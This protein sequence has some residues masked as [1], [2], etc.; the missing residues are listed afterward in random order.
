MNRRRSAT[1]GLLC[2]MVQGVV[3]AG[4]T[5]LTF[6]GN[7]KLVKTPGGQPA[8]QLTPSQGSTQGSVFTTNQ[9]QFD[10]ELRFH[11]FFQFQINPGPACPGDGMAFVVQTQ[12]PNA[13]GGGGGGLGYKGIHPSVAV[14]FDAF[15]NSPFDPNN[16]HVAILTQ[17]LLNDLDP[18]APYGVVNCTS[19]IGVFGCI[20]NGDIWSVWID[21]DGKNLSVAVADD[22]GTRPP[23]L[24]SYP[25][26][27]ASLLGQTSAYLGFTGGIGSCYESHYILN[28]K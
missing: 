17:G 28:W 19:P 1:I 20:A 4:S 26:D 10:P 5:G 3:A 22:S 14:E 25:I 9:V 7:A 16:N 6:N 11:T 8:I 12:G 24:I 18:Q 23:N 2:I 21:Y 15:Q 13:L 27:L